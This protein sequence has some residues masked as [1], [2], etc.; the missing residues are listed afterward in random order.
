[1][2]IHVRTVLPIFLD[3]LG[4]RGVVR[5]S[6]LLCASRGLSYHDSLTNASFFQLSP[7]DYIVLFR[8]SLVLVH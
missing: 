5:L 8:P 4:R 1:M 3:T 6:A 2:M 7:S